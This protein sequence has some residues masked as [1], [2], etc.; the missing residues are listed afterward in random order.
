MVK[1]K[2]IPFSRP[3]ISTKANHYI[4]IALSKDIQ[5]GDG[6]YSKI[7]QDRIAGLYEDPSEVILT[8]SCTAALELSLM[9]LDLKPGDEVI[10]PSFTFTS[11]ATAITKFWATP[12][13]CDIDLR[14]GCLDT[15][16]L[17]RKISPRT[18]A[19]SWV[20]YA[21]KTPNTSALKNI[22]NKYKV[23]LIE[24]AA[25]N[26][27]ILGD[28]QNELTGDFVT[29]SFHATKNIQCGE[30][31]ALL[32]RNAQYRNRAHII[33]EKGTN[34]RDFLNGRVSKYSWVD[35]GSS[36]LISEVS[37]AILM[38]QL[39]DFVVIQEKRKQIVE[40]YN[41]QLRACNQ[42]TALEN[43]QNSSHMFAVMTFSTEFRDQIVLQ[44]KAM[45]VTLVSHYEDLATSPYAVRN[46]LSSN[47][48]PNSKIFSNRILRLPVYP[49]LGAD[50]ERVVE[51]VKS[52]LESRYV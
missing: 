3:Y 50:A 34:R 36:Y 19:I 26:F 46:G 15:L 25:H 44:S 30:G 21:G 33:R 27:G 37:A 45:G 28:N 5:Q 8:P 24:D 11:I 20:N 51:V 9:L 12:I 4:E 1:E 38:S 22:A 39:D 52:I 40:Y 13:F 49:E 17:E 16:D 10:I 2:H 42:I 43:L 31:G 18:K 7:V 47:S 41:E 6:D 32:I 14:T 29:F 48:C 23:F 35:R